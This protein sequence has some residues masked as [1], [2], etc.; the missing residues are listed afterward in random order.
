LVQAQ[1]PAAEGE[2]NE[3]HGQPPGIGLA[4]S[5][6]GNRPLSAANV[7]PAG[8]DMSS[9]IRP[10]TSRPVCRHRPWSMV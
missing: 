9:S 4:N 1:A 6:A 5:N 10:T 8:D 7:R 2:L 3:F